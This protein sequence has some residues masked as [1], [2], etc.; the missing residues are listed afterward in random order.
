MFERIEEGLNTK[1]P[2]ENKGF[3]LL[4]KLGFK[5][6]ETLGKKQKGLTEPLQIDLKPNKHGIEFLDPK[7]ARMKE[8]VK[9]MQKYSTELSEGFVNL[10]R[11]EF[12]IKKLK[13]KLNDCLK[14]LTSQPLNEYSLH[15][16]ELLQYL[17]NEDIPF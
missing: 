4:M 9:M 3:Q 1:I 7:K 5:E 13:K 15:L 8:K 11:H 12:I 2:K 6:G 17:I 10:K 14:Y 16:M